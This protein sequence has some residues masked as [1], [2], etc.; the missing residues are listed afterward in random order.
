[1]NRLKDNWLIVA[2]IVFLLVCLLM[3][4]V[5][6]AA[7]IQI[8][9][10]IYPFDG[11]RFQSGNTYVGV[12]GQ[13]IIRNSS[14]AAY[15]YA[16]Q[17][18]GL[19]NV[20]IEGVTFDDNGVEINN[21]AKNITFKNCTFSDARRQKDNHQAIFLAGWSDNIRFSNCRVINASQAMQ[22]YGCTNVII[23]DFRIEKCGY[24]IKY[25]TNGA[26]NVY[27][28][29]GVFDQMQW[30]MGLE[31]Q[32]DDPD[33]K[34]LIVE[35]IAY[36]NPLL[37]AD[38]SKNGN[39]TAFSIPT[40]KMSGILVHR[41]YAD[42]EA[43]VVDNNGNRT[44]ERRRSSQN[45]RG[46]RIGGEIGG[47]RPIWT[48]CWFKNLN[49]PGAITTSTEAQVFNNLV[50]DCVEGVGWAPPVP[51]NQKA[52]WIAAASKNSKLD[53]NDAN[54]ILPA[55]GGWTLVGVVPPGSSLPQSTPPPASA[56][57]NAPLQL[58]FR[59]DI[60]ANGKPTFTPIAAPTTAATLPPTL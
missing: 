16:A 34:N 57:S 48:N 51:D 12:P 55:N 23:E 18:K 47:T 53:R 17:L 5:G 32:N 44:G 37:F 39:A 60:D 52:A 4:A 10:G 27:I 49:D 35:D 42:G 26:A 50:Q 21:G 3:S 58:Y 43:W 7:T 2:G 33:Q 59:L 22:I 45:W 36:V 31:I 24:G 28:R 11:N 46:L 41:L 56:P 8:P 30:T 25:G 6:A 29:R 14:T 1:M 54:V 15:A 20:T 40:A 9:A 19:Q 38:D 13:T